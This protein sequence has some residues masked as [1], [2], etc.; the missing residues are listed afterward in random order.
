M[1]VLEK[2]VEQA[3]RDFL[4]LD[5]WRSFKTDPCS[6]RSRGK[7]FGEVGMP[8]CLFVRYGLPISGQ[9]LWIEFKRPG[10]K[11]TAHQLAWHDAERARG[12]LVLVVDDIDLFREWYAKS[13]LRRRVTSASGP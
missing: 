11:P 10:K 2:H 12:A 6:D 9:I 8:D 3:V 1:K 4:A 7:G 13:G 5:G